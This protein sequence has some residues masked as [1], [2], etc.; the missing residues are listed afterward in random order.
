M[1]S[2]FNNRVLMHITAEY[3]WHKNCFKC[4]VHVFIYY[5]S[6]IIFIISMKACY[7]PLDPDGYCFKC[8]IIG[9]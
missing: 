8:G 6:E 9:L 4:S 1:R 3:L 2:H 7:K 5:L